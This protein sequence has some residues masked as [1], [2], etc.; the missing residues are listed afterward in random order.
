MKNYQNL[1]IGLGT[2][3]SPIR[4]K[5]YYDG[6]VFGIIYEIEKYHSVTRYFIYWTDGIK[7]CH[8]EEQIKQA[9]ILFE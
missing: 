6:C 7:T 9:T 5:K 3:I 8:V 2:I 1:N 4:D